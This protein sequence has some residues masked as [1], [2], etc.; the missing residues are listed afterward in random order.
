MHNTALLSIASAAAIMGISS[1][2]LYNYCANGTFPSV[3]IGRRVMIRRSDLE[4]LINGN[5]GVSGS[6]RSAT[7]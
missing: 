5:V 1:R 6:D 2:S 7:D 3:R 4:A